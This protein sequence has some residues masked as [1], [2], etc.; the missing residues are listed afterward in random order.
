VN[1]LRLVYQWPP[2]WDGVT[3]GPFELTRA[4]VAQ[5]H[6]VRV[7]C[8]GWPRWPVEA[9]PDVWVR[10]LPSGLRRVGPFL[11]TA[12]S[13]LAW[14]LRWHNWADVIHGHGHLPIWYHLWRRVFGDR[15]P[16]ILHLHITAAG[17]RASLE[18]WGKRARFWAGRFK[19]PLHELSD[20]IGCEVADAVICVSQSVRDEAATYYGADARKLHVVLNGVNT[21]LFTSEGGDARGRYGFDADDK[22]MLF[23]GG[24]H[25]RKRPDLLLETL[26]VLPPD[27]KLLVVGRGLMEAE[28]HSR[29]KQ[30]G[31]TER[32]CFTEYVPYPELAPVY[33]TADVFTL[34][35]EY[36]GYPKAILEALA[37][38]V[39]V[40]TTPSFY[41]DEHIAP[42]LTLLQK[43]MPDE[44]AAAVQRAHDEPPVDVSRVQTLYDW[45]VKAEEIWCVCQ[46]VRMKYQ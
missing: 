43:A 18:V 32:V 15:K 42:H 30:L 25:P 3:A 27:W 39:P 1:I 19:W 26:A 12:P 17:R 10:R 23:V 20:R 11:T 24:L 13:A 31:L 36:E 35:S 21:G 22:V 44:V 14:L 4:Q 6:S 9:V 34:L 7:I 45:Q 46:K 41:V 2:P 29:A 38:G 5:G 40:V 33:R 28:L 16:Y 37:C 8:G